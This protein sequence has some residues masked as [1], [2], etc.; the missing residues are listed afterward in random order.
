M[1]VQNGINHVKITLKKSIEK[2][3]QEWS[4]L[5]IDKDRQDKTGT[6]VFSYSIKT[7]FLKQQA[8]LVL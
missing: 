1:T 5:N 8:T 4:E 2:N 7:T 6:K 3:G